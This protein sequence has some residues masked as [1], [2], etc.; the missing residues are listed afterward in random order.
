MSQNSFVSPS[1]NSEL[2]SPNNT[3]LSYLLMSLSIHLLKLPKYWEII[4]LCGLYPLKSSHLVFLKFISM[5]MPSSSLGHS[6]LVICLQGM[7]SL[8]KIIMPPEFELLSR[9]KWLY[10]SSTN[11]FFGKVSSSFV[12]DIIRISMFSLTMHLKLRTNF[13]NN[14]Y[15]NGLWQVYLCSGF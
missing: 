11:C 12:S 10:Q 7:S 2:K 8:I 6:A 4:C 5:N 14:L 13:S 9:R 15:L 3:I 1:N